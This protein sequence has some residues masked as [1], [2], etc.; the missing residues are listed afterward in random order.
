MKNNTGITLV[1]LVVTIIVLL[2]LAAVSISAVMG[3]NG[4][5]T[6]ASNSKEETEIGKE[7]EQ[8]NSAKME[9]MV[10]KTDDNDF[11]DITI[12]ELQSKLDSDLGIGIVKVTQINSRLLVTYIETN[13]SYEVDPVWESIEEDINWEN[14]IS[15]AKKHS[16][17]DLLNEDIGVGTDGKPVNLNNW[18]YYLNGNEIHLGKISGD[19]GSSGTVGYI[20][21]ILDGEIVGKVPEYIIIEGTAYPVVHLDHTFKGLGIE[22]ASKIPST[23]ETMLATFKDCTLLVEAPVLPEGLINMGDKY[24]YKTGTF[25]GCTN[26]ETAPKIPSSVQEM[27]KTFE[28]CSKLKGTMIIDANP[29]YLYNCFSGAATSGETLILTGLSTKLDDFINTKSSNSNIIKE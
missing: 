28:N 10:D 24:D 20:G 25:C 12:A 26:L 2:I 18:Y 15:S 21:E 23:V 9:I 4:I 5:V 11:S 7:K 22:K 17:Q 13:R 14:V 1:A 19:Y 27:S 6:R 8:V 3:E 29:S 16:E